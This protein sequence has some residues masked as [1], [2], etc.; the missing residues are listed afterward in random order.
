MSAPKSQ[1][2]TW[3]VYP[4]GTK[5]PGYHICERV[6][7]DV[8][9]GRQAGDWMPDEIAKLIAAAPTL[10]NTLA[11]IAAGCDAN[12]CELNRAELMRFAEAA[13]A[14]LA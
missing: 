14:E 3:K 7:S 10:A 4:T 13:L 11:Q 6:V 2:A 9:N 8:F 12:G 5:V 1:L